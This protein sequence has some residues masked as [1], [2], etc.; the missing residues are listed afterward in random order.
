M[1]LYNISLNNLRR[2]KGK[3]IFLVLGLVIGVAT[4][5]ALLSISESMSKDIEARLNQ[6]GANIVMVPKNENLSLSYGG[7]NIGGVNYKVSELDEATIPNIRNIKNNKNLGIVSPKVLGTVKV[8]GKDVLLMGVNFNEELSLKSWWVYNGNIPKEANEVILGSEVASMFGLSAGD[9][10]DISD[11]PFKVAAVLKATGSSDDNVIVADLREAQRVLGKEGKISMVEIAA[12]CNGCPITEITLQIAEKFPD[13]KVTALK[14][15]VMSKMQSIEMF[16]SFSLGI[17]AL[18]IFIGGLLVF[19]TMMGSVNER[20][21]E[22]GIFRSIG[23]RKGHVMQIILLEAMLIGIV[24]GIIGFFGG[25]GVA[26]AI[27]P[28]AVEKGSYAGM[29]IQIGLISLLLSVSLSLIASL[30]PSHRA[31]SLDPSNALRAL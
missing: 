14:Q 15:V 6:F 21:R 5:V 31:S 13:A 26:L 24:G 17:S 7:F 10:F 28:L 3:M 8:E 12:F 2:R 19:V 18:V 20:T 25:N 30:Y 27:I 16:K 23:F 11:R 4:V 22:I 1:K 29:N 9:V